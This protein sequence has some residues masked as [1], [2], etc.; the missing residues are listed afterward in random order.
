MFN[1]GVYLKVVFS[2]AHKDKT[3]SGERISWV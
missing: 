1:D 3:V 2:D